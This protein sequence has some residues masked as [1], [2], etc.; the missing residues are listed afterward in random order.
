MSE[1]EQAIEIIDQRIESLKEI[2]SRLAHEFGLS[3][4][5]NH[6][7]HHKTKPKSKRDKRSG[8]TKTKKDQLT[9][10]IKSHGP[11]PRSVLLEKSGLRPGTIAGCLADKSRFEQLEDGRWAVAS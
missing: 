10:F 11:Q 6:S 9:D 4:N 1:I 2:R 8:S 3:K 7:V 5:G